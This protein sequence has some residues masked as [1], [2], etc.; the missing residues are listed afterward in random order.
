MTRSI[1]KFLAVSALALSLAACSG[2]GDGTKGTDKAAPTDV[3]ITQIAPPAGKKWE[4]TVVKT[5]EG[6][7]LMGNPDAK[8][9]IIEYAALSCSHC[10]DFS[11]GGAKELK[12]KYVASGQVSLEMRNFM[13]NFLD[14]V[15][16]AVTHCVGAGR[17]FP[18][19]DNIFAS[20]KELFD[21]AQSA[22]QKEL[23]NIAS[24]AQ[25][26]QPAAIAKVLKLDQFFKARGVTEAELNT[27]LANSENLAAIEK[28]M[29]EGTKQYNITG[30]PTFVIDG[31]KAEFTADK[32]LW[33][34]L[35]AAIN[36]KL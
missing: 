33:D 18:L 14:L 20:Q 32:P 23:Q 22:D 9:K 12:S 26:D 16:T 4:E 17:Y 31:K 13:L 27:C 28:T 3:K 35:Q 19:S 7:F 8:V 15:P 34:S 2:S 5:P 6:G 1:P 36:A 29:G 11:T 10:A 25:R 30:T 21:L 24:V